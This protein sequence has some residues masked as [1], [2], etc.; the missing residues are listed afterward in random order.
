MLDLYIP[1]YMDTSLVDVDMN[2]EYIRIDV[3]GKITQIRFGVEV[4]VDTTRIL[5]SQTTGALQAIMPK[6]GREMTPMY[7]V[8]EEDENRKPKKEPNPEASEKDEPAAVVEEIMEQGE[9]HTLGD[10]VNE[11]DESSDDDLPPLEC[12]TKLK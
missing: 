1:K 11:A 4:M 9:P 6:C 2:P 7:V 10:I 12:T 3:K 8:R 5:R